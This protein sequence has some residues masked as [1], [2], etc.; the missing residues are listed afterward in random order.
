MMIMCNEMLAAAA[1][2]DV[3]QLDETLS[4]EVFANVFKKKRG[5]K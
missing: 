1:E 2:R 5:G 4:F 3:S